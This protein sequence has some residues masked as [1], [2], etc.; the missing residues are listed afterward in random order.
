MAGVQSTDAENSK[1]LKTSSPV[2]DDVKTT[3]SRPVQDVAKDRKNL[4]G[5]DSEIKKGA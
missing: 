1:P 4:G 5:I 2:E 3:V